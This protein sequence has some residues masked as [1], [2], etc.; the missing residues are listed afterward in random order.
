MFGTEVTVIVNCGKK[1]DSKIT[2]FKIPLV[3]HLKP[4]TFTS[5]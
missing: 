5:T 1:Q 3:L 2:D 4:L